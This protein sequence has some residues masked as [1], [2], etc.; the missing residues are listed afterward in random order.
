[1]EYKLMDLDTAKYI[2]DKYINNIDFFGS[3]D[4]QAVSRVC[5]LL[6]EE[7]KKLQEKLNTIK[8]L[9]S[10]RIES[11]NSAIGNPEH[12][13]VSKN[14][15]LKRQVITCETILKIIEGNEDK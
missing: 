5:E 3:V 12:S 13:I 7:N 15:L 1:M 2:A 9:T 8:E 10:K 11:C 4:K 6:L 14:E